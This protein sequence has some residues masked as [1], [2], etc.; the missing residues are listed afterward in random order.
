MNSRE[1]VSLYV[2]YH[3]W[4]ASRFRSEN[5]KRNVEKGQFFFCVLWQN[6]YG[7]MFKQ[8]HFEAAVQYFCGERIS[9]NQRRQ[10]ILRR[11]R[12]HIESVSVFCK[13]GCIQ[14]YTIFQNF[15]KFWP[16]SWT[17]WNISSMTTAGSN[18][19]G[20]YQKV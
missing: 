11:N 2:V 5:T 8:P 16:L 19:S 14:N 4:S 12:I 9:C 10:L 15:T 20:L 1:Y 18:I 13:Q 3:T 17:R 6:L 7:N